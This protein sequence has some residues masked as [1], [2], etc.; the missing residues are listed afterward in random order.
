MNTRFLEAFVWVAR[1]GSFRSAAERLHI[2]QAAIS[3]RIA[4]LEEEF[5][6]RLFDRD[7][8]EVRTTA[9]GRLL[10]VHAERILELAREMGSALISDEG[11]SGAV[12]IGVVETIVHTWLIPF[13]ERLQQVHSK[14]AIQLTAE[15]TFRLHEQLRRGQ[16]DV[17]LQTD[18]ILGEGI[19][20]QP[21]GAMS[22]GWIGRPGEQW[23]GE[24]WPDKQ[25]PERKPIPLGR[26]IEQPIITMTRGS[27]P[28]LALLQACRT[29]R[30]EAGSVHCVGSLATIIRLVRA[31]FG[32][33]LVPLAPFR[34]EL[35][36]GELI[37]IPCTARLADLRLTVSHMDDPST[38]TAD[39]VAAMACL[40]ARRFA[41]AVGPDLAIPAPLSES[42]P[43]EL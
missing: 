28:H 1:L 6:T 20:N 14:L 8:R 23:P 31:G 41:E 40:E 12:R 35:A 11:L 17:A 22:M 7:G 30:V 42:L 15:P 29:E 21:V 39:L 27:Q 18:P 43:L 38:R 3:S 37:T 34:E 32:T 5:G 13:L 36:E 26:L 9:A 33:A 16:L 24:Q 4:S 10:L 2:T 25:R 19:L